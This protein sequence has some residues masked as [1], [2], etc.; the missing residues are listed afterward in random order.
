[1]RAARSFDSASMHRNNA[2]VTR[3]GACRIG[4]GD[5]FRRAVALLAVTAWTLSGFVCPMPDHGMGA[6]QAHDY[7]STLGGHVH[8]HGK[9]PSQ[10]EP[11]L[12]CELVCITHAIA[13]PIATPTPE[14]A[15]ALSF[16]AANEA[17]A[18]LV[19]EAD[20]SGR[21]IP[22]SNGPPQNFYQRFATFWSHAPPADLS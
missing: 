5:R 14:K 19:P 22:L 16:A 2:R 13:Q 8:R 12:C 9:S 21:L 10:P 11:D 20:P 7:A 18:S 1:M 17:L 3:L 6:V 4:S 15:P